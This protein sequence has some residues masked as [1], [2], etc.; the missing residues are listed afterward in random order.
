MCVL[1]NLF[2]G[3]LIMP[4]SACYITTVPSTCYRFLVMYVYIF[5][6]NLADYWRAWRDAAKMVLS[7]NNSDWVHWTQVLPSGNGI[8]P[9]NPFTMDGWSRKHQHNARLRRGKYIIL[10]IL[11]NF[12]FFKFFFVLRWLCLPCFMLT[13]IVLQFPAIS[14]FVSF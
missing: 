14:W 7:S 2:V 12:A 9:L 6:G 11:K 5:W 13:L 10:R 8:S 1:L 4:F 3:F